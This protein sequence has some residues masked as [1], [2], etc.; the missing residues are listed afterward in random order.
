MS[1][2]N[3][4]NDNLKQLLISQ[5]E[6]YHRQ[7]LEHALFVETDE[8]FHHKWIHHRLIMLSLIPE[9]CRRPGTRVVD[10]GGG[11]GWMSTLLSDLGL[12]CVNI[13]KLFLNGA[14]ENVDGQPL[15][16]LLR[17]YCEEKGVKVLARDALL[18][19]MPFTDEYFDLAIC[20]ELIEH[21]PNSPKPMLSEIYR[22]LVEGGWLILTTPNTVS[23]E[24]RM[25]TL[26]GRSPHYDFA[27]FYNLQQGYPIGTV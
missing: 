21:L 26:L 5:Q 12:E 9:E 10:V 22:T 3:W 7:G 16:P 13:D 19:A 2:L 1:D 23:L 15:V 4:N 11:K 18:H 24:K 6:E 8:A 25:V 27:P 17:S 14:A 20:S